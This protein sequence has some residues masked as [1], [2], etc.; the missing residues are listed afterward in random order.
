MNSPGQNGKAAAR[1]E[2][3]HRLVTEAVMAAGSVAIED[4]ARMFDVSVM[5]IHRDL[6]RLETQNVLRKSRG[7]ATAL[8]SSTVESNDAYRRSQQRDEKRALASAALEFIQ[9][10]HTVM[11]DDSTTVL[12]LLDMLTTKAPLTVA[13]N[14][15]SVINGLVAA[16]EVELVQL[17]GEFRAWCN[18]F[19]GQM[20]LDSIAALHADVLIM[21]TSAVT[22]NACYHQRQD[23]ISVKRAL[24]AAAESR[25]LVVDHTKFERR[26]LFKLCALS[27][28]D[29]I[30]VDSATPESTIDGL[31]QQHG[32]VTVA[33]GAN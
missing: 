4:L 14:S 15:L 6:D 1:Q 30:V 2:E 9:P 20:T 25:V 8:P 3:R 18:A 16:E 11:L 27:D 12:P 13:S 10:G 24:I 19:M 23:T 7:V 22:G 5:T 21:S 17:G 26:A 29:H 32:S 31:R 28:F 33:P